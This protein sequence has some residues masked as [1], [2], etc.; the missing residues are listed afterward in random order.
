MPVAISIIT[1]SSNFIQAEAGSNIMVE[2]TV[3]TVI[4]GMENEN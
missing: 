1:V 2:V 3:K 4:Y